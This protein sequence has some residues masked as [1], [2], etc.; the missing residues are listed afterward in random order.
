MTL[1]FPEIYFVLDSKRVFLR[2]EETLRIELRTME[3]T[4]KE[5]HLTMA[6]G[7]GVHHE[8]EEGDEWGYCIQRVEVEE[9]ATVVQD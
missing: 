8:S 1:A 9:D 5:V 2:V 7:N 4:Q 6:C 3:A